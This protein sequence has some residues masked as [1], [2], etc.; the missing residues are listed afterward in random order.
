MKNDVPQPGPAQCLYAPDMKGKRDRSQS[1]KRHGVFD[2]SDSSVLSVP[3]GFL[4]LPLP[5]VD[6]QGA[7][8][9]TSSNISMTHSEMQ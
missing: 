9:S 1:F 2:C 5:L 4:L 3:I 8:E 7:W 6:Y